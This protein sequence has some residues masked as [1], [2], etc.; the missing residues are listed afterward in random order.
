MKG[1][2]KD[3]IVHMPP[4]SEWD[5]W[6]G[7]TKE[8]TYKL[9]NPTHHVYKNIK[10]TAFTYIES[11]EQGQ[12]STKMNYATVISVPDR[13]PPKSTVDVKVKVTLPENYNETIM[14][15]GEEVEFPFRIATK[16]IGLKSI[17]EF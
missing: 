3:L 7:E 4:D 12:L 6:N 2:L 17:E 13:V 15:E 9:Q 8:F 5:L 10:F 1:N 11:K 16:A 14:Y